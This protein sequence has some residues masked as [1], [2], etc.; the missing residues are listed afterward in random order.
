MS[1]ALPPRS[2]RTGSWLARVGAVYPWT[3]TLSVCID[4]HVT[5]GKKGSRQLCQTDHVHFSVHPKPRSM[6]V[7]P[8]LE[9]DLMVFD[10]SCTGV[11]M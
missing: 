1:A 6:L 11:P 7:S 9:C 8:L 3:A 4:F 2:L 5:Q 10:L